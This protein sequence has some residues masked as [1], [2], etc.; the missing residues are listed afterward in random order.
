MI[1]PQDQE[2]LLKL[3]RNRPGHVADLAW[4]TGL[5]RTDL[6]AA[7]ERLEH[8]GY[9][10]RRGDELLTHSPA[11]VS[12]E[13]MRRVLDDYVAATQ[14]LANDVQALTERLLDSLTQANTISGG[15][16]HPYPV[17]TYSGML[18]GPQA[19]QSMISHDPA[20]ADV[21]GLLP[22][23]PPPPMGHDM[24]RDLWATFA[25]APQ[26][27]RILVPESPDALTLEDMADG[28]AQNSEVRTL[29]EPPS[30]IW[31]DLHSGRVALPVV[32]GESFPASVTVV[33][34]PAATRLIATLF[35]LLWATSSPIIVP[36]DVP[37]WVP[38]MQH[39]R[40]GLSLDEAAERL[41]INP[42]SAR[43]RLER[44]MQHYGVDSIFALGVAWAQ[45]PDQG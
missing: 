38:V 13:S 10:A 11:T 15:S 21:I 45:D 43:R 31:A 17:E 35:D 39:M 22:A 14:R 1:S 20:R 7:L 30:W 16:A 19:L 23:L 6:D 8:A 25:L 26:R 37:L 41:E 5:S 18:A 32:W 27:S 28:F 4:L 29:T 40:D 3:L 36:D 12:L 24:Q 9:V 42:R 2:L 33:E 44:G 34:H